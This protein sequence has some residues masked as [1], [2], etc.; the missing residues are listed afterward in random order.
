M[1]FTPHQMFWG[2][3]TNKNKI[4]ST[5]MRERKRAYKV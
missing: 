5:R 4:G 1:I 2:D 3:V